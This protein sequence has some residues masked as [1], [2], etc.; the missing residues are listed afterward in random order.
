MRNVC[1]KVVFLVEM[2]IFSNFIEKIRKIPIT[3]RLLLN[4]Y[5]M[6]LGKPCMAVYIAEIK[7]L[8]C[9]FL[10]VVACEAKSNCLCYVIRWNNSFIRNAQIISVAYF[11]LNTYNKS[12]SACIYECL[13]FVKTIQNIKAIISLILI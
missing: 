1:E 6:S 9:V 8:L 3:F 10:C 13:R 7:V 4:K 2:E 11:I 5:H 12:N